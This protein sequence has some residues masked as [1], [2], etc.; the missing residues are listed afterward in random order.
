MAEGAGA[1]ALL[2]ANSGGFL[3]AFD[4][5][6]VGVLEEAISMGVVPQFSIASAAPISLRA[7]PP[8]LAEARSPCCCWVSRGMYHSSARC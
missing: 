1:E 8:C 6:A 7:L 5:R 2:Q 4:A 3:R